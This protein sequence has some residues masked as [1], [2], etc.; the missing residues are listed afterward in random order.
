MA[1]EIWFVNLGIKINSLN[2]IAFSVFGIDVYWYGIILGMGTLLGLLMVM[3][4]AKRTY[5]DTEI[6]S[7]FLIIGIIFSVIGA[8]LYYVIWSWDSF[9]DDLIKIFAI[10]Q[11]GIAIYGS[12]IGAVIAI[13]IYTKIRKLNFFE[14]T[15]TCVFGLLVGQI[16]GRW[17]NFVN[18]EAFGGFTD[19]IFAL[20]YLKSQVTNVNQN[21]LDHIVEYNGVE[22]I[23]VHPTF[24]YESL[25]NL[26][27]FIL[28]N[29]YKDNKKFNGEITALYF[30]GYG[31]GRFWIEG[32]RTD[33]LVIGNTGIA[34]SQVV[35]VIM[36]LVSIIF[37]IYSRKRSRNK[38]RFKL[39]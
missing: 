13:I 20:R 9:K 16:I 14:F 22:Y 37:I 23:Q 19:S 2:R 38:Y 39:K 7:D 15:D 36:V 27:L 5:Q 3:H 1:P 11:G 25:W 8:R 10:R 17:G 29:L 18:R 32:L 4:E 26:G 34:I 6:Y 12:I 31:I 24:L 35:S 21:I 33:Q 30:I 28:L